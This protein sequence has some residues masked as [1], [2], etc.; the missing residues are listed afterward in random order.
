MALIGKRIQY[1]FVTDAYTPATIPQAKLAEYLADLACLYGESLAYFVTLEES[2]LAIV[3]EV[4]AA[5]ESEVLENLE[6]AE[7]DDPSPARSAY[8]SIARRVTA[9]GGR[10]AFVAKEGAKILRFP[11]GEPVVAELEYGPFWQAGY[12][13]GTVILIGGRTETVSVKIQDANGRAFTCKA[14][15]HLARRLREYLFEQPVRLSGQGRWR[16]DAA[17]NWRL[18]TFEVADFRPLSGES[19]LETI[20]RLRAISGAWKDRPDPLAELEE[21]RRDN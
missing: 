19:L 11:A 15:R 13:T 14:D 16:R 1:R 4:D 18:D 7:A 12:L 5:A 21:M 2:S 6:A 9:D 17:G 10:T 3:S 20:S 8:T